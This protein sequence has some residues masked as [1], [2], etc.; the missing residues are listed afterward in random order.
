MKIRSNIQDQLEWKLFGQ[1]HGQ[2]CETIRLKIP[3]K[4]INLKTS[5]TNVTEITKTEHDFSSLSKREI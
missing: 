2:E 4:L 1:E 5:E 3:K